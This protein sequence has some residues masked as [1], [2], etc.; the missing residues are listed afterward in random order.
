[1]W[2]LEQEP[3]L[4]LLEA[5]KLARTSF[6]TIYLWVTKGSRSPTGEMVR[7]EAFRLGGHWVTSKAALSRFAARLT[8]S[9]TEVVTA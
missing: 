9:M 2:D 3:P 5:A 6:P 8:P 1:M 7:L 4:T